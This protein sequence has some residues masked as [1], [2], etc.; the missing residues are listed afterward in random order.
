MT[1]MAEPDIHSPQPPDAGCRPRRSVRNL[2][3]LGPAG[4]VLALAV[5]LV[6]TGMS[7]SP[8]RFTGEFDRL[9]PGAE[10]ARGWQVEDLPIAGTPEAQRMVDELLNFDQAVFRTY[11]RGDLRISIYLAYWRPGKMQ[12]KDIGRH[13]PDS[14]WV[15]SGWKRTAM[16]TRED[17]RLKDGRRVRLTEHRTFVAQNQVE[18]LVFWHVIEEATHSYRTGGRPPWHWLVTDSLRR[19]LNQK[20]EQFF[21]RISSN[22]PLEGFWTNELVQEV[23]GRIP[24]IV[25][26]P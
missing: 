22:R 8:P 6:M 2:L 7:Q 5:G 24:G 17:L 9:V 4:L 14:C 18:H 16:H 12:P 26:R 10:E 25:E 11:A 1:I 15:L 20:P 19:G 13:T 23:V 3:V 21:L